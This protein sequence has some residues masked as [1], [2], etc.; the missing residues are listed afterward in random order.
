MPAQSLARLVELPPQVLTLEGRLRDGGAMLAGG[1]RLDWV[2]EPTALLRGRAAATARLSGAD[3]DVTGAIAAGLGSVVLRD[4]RGRA[5]AGLLRLVPGGDLACDSRATL[6]MD[7]LG[8][9]G[10]RAVAAGRIDIAEGTCSIDG[11]SAPLPAMRVS[12][13]SEGDDALA[14]AETEAGV[15][16][17]SV[18]V[19]GDRRAILRLEPEGAAMVPGLP[20]GAP[21]ILEIPF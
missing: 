19:T 10:S 16:V 2:L 17:G 1:Y 21:T 4:V 6:D 15:R 20:S 13:G 7:V 12:L 9:T 3:T 8:V 5:G 14:V 18:R 11:Q